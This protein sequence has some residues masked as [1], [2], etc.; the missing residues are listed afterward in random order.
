[1]LKV[2]EDYLCR[3]KGVKVV[4]L[5]AEDMVIELVKGIRNSGDTKGFYH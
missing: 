5:D 2:I 3:I 4:R 1:M